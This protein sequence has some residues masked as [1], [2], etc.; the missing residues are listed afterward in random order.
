MLPDIVRTEKAPT[1]ADERI[2]NPGKRRVTTGVYGRNDHL[3]RHH[4]AHAPHSV[5]NRPGQFALRARRHGLD[6]RCATRS[7]VGLHA[8]KR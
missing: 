1:R 2:A 7:V 8:E 3:V 5:E 4:A 6:S